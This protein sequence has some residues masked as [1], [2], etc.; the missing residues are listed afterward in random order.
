MKDALKNLAI[1]IVGG[2]VFFGLVFYWHNLRGVLPAIS[3]P[4][5]DISN[6]IPQAPGPAQNNTNMPLKLPDGFSI[7][8]FAENLPNARVMAFDPEGKLLI[9]LTSEGKIVA[10]SDEN[11][12]GVSDKTFTVLSGLRKPHGVAIKCLGSAGMPDCSLYVAEESKI[13]RYNYSQVVASNSQKIADL[14]AGGGHF[15]RTIGFGPDGKLYV[16]VGSSCNVCSE[17]DNRRAKI[18]SMNADGS[19]V[20]EFASGLRNT[21][22]FTWHNSQMWGTDMGRDLLGD[23]VPPDEINLI[24]Q[25]NNY[26]WPYCYDDKVHDS[27]FDRANAHSC[28][29]TVEPKVK[30]QAHSAPLGLSFVPDDTDHVGKFGRTESWPEDYYNNLIVAFHGSWN[31]SVPTGYK[32]VR[33]KFDKN[34]NYSGI[35]DFITGW[36]SGG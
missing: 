25:G 11:G 30:L 2:I 24:E 19:N 8:I 36:I 20:Q 22:F 23:N 10:L 13:T 12:D 35:E 14:P 16:S 29:Q 6:L 1:I 18:L 9:S 27:S 32:L 26:G 31:R 4:S 15:T 3:P 5:K 7:S 34:G 21:V 28:S 33:I 17:S